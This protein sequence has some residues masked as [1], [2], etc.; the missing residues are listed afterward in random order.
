MHDKP[1][2]GKQL[3]AF[4]RAMA[5]WVE[6]KRSHMPQVFHE[7][8][9]DQLLAYI[10]ARE[11]MPADVRETLAEYGWRLE[12]QEGHFLDVLERILA[13]WHLP[14]QSG[15]AWQ[16]VTKTRA[17]ELIRQRAAAVLGSSSSDR[18]TRIMVTMD[19]AWVDEPGLI[20]RL[21][22]CGMD[23]ARINCAYSSP[24][25][26]E[27]LIAIIRQTERML[28]P[29]GRRCRIYMD[30]PGPK[31][32]ID[33]LAVQDGPMKL[34]VKENQYG[35]SAES[36]TGLLSFSAVPPLSSLPREVSFV[37]KL[38]AD[39]EETVAEGDELLFTD[40]R[41]KKR[42]LQVMRSIAPSCFVVR[43]FQTAYVQS[44]M[45]L[46]RGST[47]FTLSS[48][49]CLP[50]RALVTAGTPLHI[51]FHEAALFSSSSDHGVKL[52]TT[53][54]KAWRNVRTGDRL[55]FNDGRITARVVKVGEGHVEA[56]VI[57]DGGKRKAIKQGT[58][59]HLPDSFCHLAVPPLTDR[60]LEWL[61]F[62][63]KWAD[64]VGLSFVQAPHDVRKLHGLLAE[65]GAGSLPVIAKIETRAALHQF[66][67]ILLEGLKLPAFGVMIAR[68]DLALEIGFEHLAAMQCEM[69]SL[70]RA[71][72]IP[73]I[74][75]TQVLEQMAKKGVPSRPELS[76]VFLGKQAQC[77]MLNK[78]A[79]IAEAVRL[80]AFLLANEDSHIGH[81][82]DRLSSLE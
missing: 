18:P 7:E 77:I 82:T 76:D 47:S 2:F 75:A 81:W 40:V 26:W 38:T 50:K 15:Q 80:L 1:D 6:Q 14:T 68:G 10:Y 23:I 31:V 79:H 45:K 64:I 28:A 21:L 52:T 73:V 54:P 44:G 42:S 59:I 51:Y 22:L 43:L 72:H 25:T 60:D 48:A 30:L 69:L 4:Y 12:G 17:H 65:Q 5:E 24:D 8:S 57:A 61:P 56:K 19:A 33:R 13:C 29:Q 11:H 36:L 20:E 63:A 74:W 55:Y 27:A 32:R 62:I 34:T 67:R 58:G 39:D 37:W 71:A 3:A 41:G 16:K 46:R 35:E 78:G 49:L 70:C 53:L 66:V 9:R